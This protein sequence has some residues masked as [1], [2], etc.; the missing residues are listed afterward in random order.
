MY[1]RLN[2]N[3]VIKNN[4][5]KLQLNQIKCVQVQYHDELVQSFLETHS[6]TYSGTKQIRHLDSYKEAIAR[7]LAV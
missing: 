1:V 6:T 3:V 5:R 2:D 7:N 4:N